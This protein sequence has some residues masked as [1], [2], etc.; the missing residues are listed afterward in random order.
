[1]H[2]TGTSL[3]SNVLSVLG[4]DMADDIT[5]GKGN[6]RGHWER[7]EIVD[8]HERILG[9]F[10]R[11]YL[12]Q[13]HD[14][15]LPPGWWAEPRVSQIRQ[16]TISFLKGR[17]TDAPFGFK[18]PRTVRLL[19]MWRQIFSEMKLSPKFVLCLRNPAQVA[20]SLHARDGLDPTIGEYRWL[21][22]MTDFFRYVGNNDFCVIEYENWFKNPS[23]SL[24]ILHNHLYLDT[25]HSRAELDQ[26]IIDIIDPE[27]RHDGDSEHEASV[28]LVRHVY[29]LARSSGTDAAARARLHELA[30]QFAVFDRLNRWVHREFESA[31]AVAAKLPAAE[32]EIADL[33]SA[34]ADSAAALEE[35]SARAAAAEDGLARLRIEVDAAAARLAEAEVEREAARGRA[36][37]AQE[38]LAQ[39]RA[40]TDAAQSRLAGMEAERDAALARAAGDEQVAA[41]TRAELEAARTRLSEAQTERDAAFVRADDAEQAFAE[42]RAETN[43]AR[44]RLAEL[45]T[46]RDA[47]TARAAGAELAF[48]EARDEIGAAHARLAAIEAERDAAAARAAGMEHAMVQA[49]AEATDLRVHLADSNRERDQVHARLEEREDEFVRAGSERAATAERLEQELAA[50]QALAEDR[51]ASLDVSQSVLAEA[52]TTGRVLGAEIGSLRTRVVTLSDELAAARHVN[53]AMLAA[54]RDAPAPPLTPPPRESWF[55]VLLRRVG[56]QTGP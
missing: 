43:V 8:F 25:G 1:M 21:V 41:E 27:L 42:A 23:I 30:A 36:G 47:V 24:D 22:H 11:T 40:E 12:G 5:P 31:A 13:F 4:V 29:Q 28:P 7:W 44:A 38:V 33:Q 39:A 10:N 32:S 16:E 17:M 9:A 15:P 48:A 56:L 14:F 19:P 2:R 3:C 45:E 20:R 54:L 18:D 46:E 35:A 26:A 53:T 50:A 51:L 49:T 34:S 6:D 55:A 52:Q 37:A